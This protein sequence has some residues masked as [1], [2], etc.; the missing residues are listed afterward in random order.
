LYHKGGIVPL[1]YTTS[2]GE[3][4]AVDPERNRQIDVIVANRADDIKVKAI[5]RNTVVPLI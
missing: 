5:L 1:V 2:L 4:T 3:P